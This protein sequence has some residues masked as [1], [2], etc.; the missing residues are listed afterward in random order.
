[1]KPR[2]MGIYF[3]LKIHIACDKILPHQDQGVTKIS[4]HGF[5]RCDKNVTS[6]AQ[7]V[8]PSSPFRLGI[9]FLW[10][11]SLQ[12][13]VSLSGDKHYNVALSALAQVPGYA[14][15]GLSAKL[16]HKITLLGSL[17]LASTVSITSYFLP[18]GRFTFLGEIFMDQL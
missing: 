17:L 13:S 1:M 3:L 6:G 15:S 7:S 14:L 11:G 8:K 18:D 12:Q 2:A 4:H 5:Q 9:V 10:Y 16:G